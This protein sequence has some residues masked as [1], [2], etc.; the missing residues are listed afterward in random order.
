MFWFARVSVIVRLLTFQ[1]AVVADTK[2]PAADAA[3]ET[4]RTEAPANDSKPAKEEK[5]RKDRQTGKKIV[6][7]ANALRSRIA[8]IVWLV[9]V[10]CA[11]FLAIAA[12]L[13]ALKTN[14][15]NALVRF[16]TDGARF[17][18]LK[19]FSPKDGL[20]T[21]SKDPN[22]IKGSL[23]NWGL[24]AVAYLV[25]GKVLDRLIRPWPV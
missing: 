22:L 16:I 25:V 6:A 20:F 23:I 19:V 8:S 4:S 18:D 10:V 15:N 3:S 24:G 11:L 2:K 5:P 14:P 9:A 1:G 7:G 13:V 17:L 12:L 21:P